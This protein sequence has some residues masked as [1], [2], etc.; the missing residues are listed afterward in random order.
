VKRAAVAPILA[1]ACAATASA[2]TIHSGTVKVPPGKRG[3]VIAT[4]P[5]PTRA[6][7][8]GLNATVGEKAALELTS[9]GAGGRRAVA[10]AINPERPGTGTLTVL[11]YCGRRPIRRTV[12]ASTTVG[13]QKQA[14][15]T[16]VCPPNTS[17]LFGGFRAQIRPAPGPEVTLNGLE[18][19]S[20]RRWRVSAVNLEGPSGKLTAIAYCTPGSPQLIARTKSVKVPYGETKAVTASCPAGKTLALGGFRSTHY[21][22]RFASIY[23]ASFARTGSRAWSVSGHKFV[24]VIGKVTAIAYCR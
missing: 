20:A 16:A 19:I 22:D 9:L 11:A 23:P 2:L 6:M 1:L 5:P 14:S 18:R 15:V 10:S 13:P 4:C 21:T 3:T 17:V 12:A 8:L 24:P 7:F